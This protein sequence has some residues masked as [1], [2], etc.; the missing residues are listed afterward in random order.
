MTSTPEDK[1]FT[2]GM[3]D[4]VVA[5][6]R[7]QFDAALELQMSF[8]NSASQFA[9]EF[10]RF[11]ASQMQAVSEEVHA[12]MQATTPAELMR[13]QLDGMRHL[14]EAYVGETEKLI[15]IA[16]ETMVETAE[17]VKSAY[18]KPET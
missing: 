16:N 15:D 1:A 13:A 17:A 14:F 4:T 8:M 2:F 6:N 11:A 18:P 10:T 5:M 12:C 7:E 9:E 3:D